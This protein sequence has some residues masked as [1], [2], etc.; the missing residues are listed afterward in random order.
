MTR[1]KPLLAVLPLVLVSL[2]CS[3]VKQPT[4]TFKAMNVTDVTAQGFTM[5]FDLDVANPNAVALPI[6]A[7]DYKI[8]LAG[9]NVLNGK[10]NPSGTIPANGSIP[11]KLPVTLTYE[12]LL[13]AEQAI[14]KGGGD[15]PY[16]L[17]G[18]LAVETGMPMLGKLRVPLQYSGTLK[19]KEIL[20]N[21]QAIMQNP[22][23]Q[24][25]AKQ[26]IGGLFSR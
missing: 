16:S 12:N 22:A 21:P 18:G 17:D 7:A 24:K 9:V 15:V 13:A 11:V 19:L 3:A 25:L 6:Q 14:I 23:A 1:I 5:A 10:A 8:G 4:A 2:A 26:L 20:N